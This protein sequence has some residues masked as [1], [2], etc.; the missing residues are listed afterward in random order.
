MQNFSS[1][2][3]IGG[4]YDVL[5]S[6]YD[7]FELL[8]N[9]YYALFAYTLMKGGITYSTNKNGIL[10]KVILNNEGFTNYVQPSI[11]K[12]NYEDK[13]Y[14]R[15]VSPDFVLYLFNNY[16]LSN[17]IQRINDLSEPIELSSTKQ[18]L[19][20]SIDLNEFYISYIIKKYQECEKEKSDDFFIIKSLY[21]ITKKITLYSESFAEYQEKVAE[22][23]ALKEKIAKGEKTYYDLNCDEEELMNYEEFDA[24]E[25][26]MYLSLGFLNN[27]I[28][29]KAIEELYKITEKRNFE[30]MK[31]SENEMILQD[32]V[33][34]PIQISID[35]DGEYDIEIDYNGSKEFMKDKKQSLNL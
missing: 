25:N 33:N 21:E 27:E 3:I 4:S 11:G 19:L 30:L 8:I 17:T 28:R 2:N 26:G 1:T 24:I 31:A 13:K 6:K 9:N 22:L 18:I 35:Y 32:E 20:N 5:G 29:K 15:R 14:Q 34:D 16:C 23:S 10:A 12:W 7:D